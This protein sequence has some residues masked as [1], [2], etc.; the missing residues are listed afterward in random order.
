MADIHVK[1]GRATTL[2]ELGSV[3]RF[4]GM[5]YKSLTIPLTDWT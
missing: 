3:D 1:T 4:A 2:D 5:A